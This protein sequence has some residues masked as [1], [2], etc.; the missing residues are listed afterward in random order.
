MTSNHY[1]PYEKHNEHIII[2]ASTNGFKGNFILN[3]N[4][5]TSVLN[6]NYYRIGIKKIKGR[7]QEITIYQFK[8][9]NISRTNHVF[10]IEDLRKLESNRFSILGILGQDIFE[11]YQVEID[12][13][14]QLIIITK[15]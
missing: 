12:E 10:D 6:K 2:Q 15:K 9:R 3:I 13:I 1:I 5:N 8:L 4:Y 7:K 11:N 14:K